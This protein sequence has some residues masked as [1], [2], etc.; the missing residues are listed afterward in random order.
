MKADWL[1]I[2]QVAM[3]T[4]VNIAYAFALGSAFF[5]AWLD[6]D[7][8]TAVAP[9]RLAWLRAQR[10][11]RASAF[12]LVAALLMWMLY[13]S[14]SISGEPL[15][16]AFGV[17]GTVLAQTHVGHAW[18]VAFLGALVLLGCAFAASSVARDGVLWLA[19]IAIAG[20]R[21]GLGHA[22]D[23][24]F[25]S[26]ALGL[27]TLHV[28]SASAWSGIV[29]AGGLAVLPALGASTARGVL[30]RTAGQVSNVAMFAV[31]FVIATGVFNALRGT[32]GSVE[33]LVDSAWGRVLLLKCALVVLAL[34]L[35]GFNRLVAMP[36][37]RRAASTAAARR[38]VNVI[39]LEAIVMIGVLVAAA[40]LAHSVPG[41]VLQG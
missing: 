1:W 38:F 4:L 18:S 24:G 36:E 15:P 35:G 23:A 3:A 5:G 6:K 21:A 12:V 28:L 29:M 9:A 20:G 32:G 13:E 7:G 31:G 30:I 27:H 33:A 11:L 25:A 22:A 8:R 2:G 37:L 16:G 19:L 41:Y 26:A 10:S 40:A 39:H 14:A 34:V 17:V